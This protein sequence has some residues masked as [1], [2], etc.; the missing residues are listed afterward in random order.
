MT[1]ARHLILKDILS[2]CTMVGICLV[3]GATLLFAQTFKAN[4]P[5]EFSE[6][7]IGDVAPARGIIVDARAPE[8]YAGGHI[9]RA[10][11][12]PVSHVDKAFSAKVARFRGRRVIVYCSGYDCKD[13]T[14]L[15]RA[16]ASAGVEGVSVYKGG[17][18]E[19]ELSGQ[20]IEK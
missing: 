4:A 13:S 11:N 17:W 19:W 15:A 16:L 7:K 10:I 6:V 2:A 8:K 1:S 3:A 12:I 5:G 9:P 20:E 18:E 14:L